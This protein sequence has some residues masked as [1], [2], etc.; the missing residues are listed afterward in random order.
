[1]HIVRNCLDSVR[2]NFGIRDQSISPVV[3]AYGPAVV[4]VEVCVPSLPQPELNHPDSTGHTYV[5]TCVHACMH[6]CIRIYT[7]PNIDTY[8]HHDV[9]CVC[10]FELS[11]SISSSDGD[12]AIFCAHVHQREHTRSSG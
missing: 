12:V 7:Q 6:A 5:G 4:D 11:H 3:P 2:E 1:M 9:V 8:I 10:V